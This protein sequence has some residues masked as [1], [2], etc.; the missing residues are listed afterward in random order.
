VGLLVAMPVTALAFV[1]AYRVL[2]GEGGPSSLAADA[3]LAA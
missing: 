2:S 1:H 3:R